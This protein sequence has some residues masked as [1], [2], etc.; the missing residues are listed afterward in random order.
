MYMFLERGPL[1]Q[2][3]QKLILGLEQ[4]YINKT[5]CYM[6]EER[7]TIQESHMEQFLF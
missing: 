2:I 5:T 1:Q 7:K 6:N 4:K 3:C